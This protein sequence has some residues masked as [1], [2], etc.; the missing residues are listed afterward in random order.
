MLN[1]N[2]SSSQGG[3]RKGAGR[4]PKGK[5]RRKTLS[6]RIAPQAHAYLLS[7]SRRQGKS[8]GAYIDEI[9]YRLMEEE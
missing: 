8:T 2:K 6:V 7:E 9:V 5:E 4:K 1:K 3:A